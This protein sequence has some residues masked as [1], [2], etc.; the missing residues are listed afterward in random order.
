MKCKYCNTNINF[1]TGLCDFSCQKYTSI[2]NKK[3]IRFSFSPKPGSGYQVTSIFVE[4]DGVIKKQ[5]KIYYTPPNQDTQVTI[6]DGI[7]LDPCDLDTLKKYL[8]FA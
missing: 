4:E 2:K 5:T 1:N 7:A 8:I 3:N 6:L